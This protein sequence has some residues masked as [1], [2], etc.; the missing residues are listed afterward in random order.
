MKGYVSAKQIQFLRV[1][2]SMISQHNY[3]N[4]CSAYFWFMPTFIST[5]KVDKKYIV[6]TTEFDKVV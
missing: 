4:Y 3:G 6:T 2:Y 5:R 1:T